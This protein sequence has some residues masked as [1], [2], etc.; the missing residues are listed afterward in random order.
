MRPDM[1]EVISEGRSCSKRSRRP[2]GNRRRQQKT[3]AEELPAREQMGMRWRR[4]REYRFW[5]GRIAPLRRFL[6]KRVG[7]PWDDIHREV[8]ARAHL[9]S[10][11]YRR[12]RQC[13]DLLVAQ[14]VKIVN[15]DVCVRGRARAE[16]DMF[17]L[18]FYVHPD[19]RCLVEIKLAKCGENPQKQSSR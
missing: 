9:D 19:T 12:L 13:I 8:C 15:G 6:E 16:Q 10:P 4:A 3:S 2:K 7:C 18:S 5:Y 14:R 11:L 1:A 17:S